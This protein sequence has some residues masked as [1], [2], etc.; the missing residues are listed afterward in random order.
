MR[1]T[2]WNPRNGDRPSD[3]R[4]RQSTA[5]CRA[6]DATYS[7]RRT[8]NF[9]IPITGLAGDRRRSKGVS[10]AVW[11]PL[12]R[13]ATS[14]SGCRR[15][16]SCHRCDRWLAG[17]CLRQILLGDRGHLALLYDDPERRRTGVREVGCH[18]LPSGSCR[19]DDSA[20]C[21]V[22]PSCSPVAVP[23]WDHSL[24]GARTSWPR[25]SCSAGRSGGDDPDWLSR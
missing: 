7:G 14:C 9:A 3:Q 6:A 21:G 11:Q 15:W 18:G 4:A 19:R 17:R 2:Q 24:M 12:W 10:G 16:P 25:W 20:V 22:G 1:S 8:H 5:L 13:T 23:L